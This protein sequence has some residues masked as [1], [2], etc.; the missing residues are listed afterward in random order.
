MAKEKQVKEETKNSFS[1]LE[2]IIL[3]IIAVIVSF[4]L[5]SFITYNINVKDSKK[6]NKY[7]ENI[8]KYYQYIIDNY[9]EDVDKSKLA[10]GAIKGML[11]SLGDEY[12]YVLGEEDA[13]NFDIELEGEY[14]G[15]GIEIVTNNKDEIIIYN[16]LNNSP[17]AKAGLKVGDIIKEVDGIAYKDSKEIA[18]YIRNDASHIIKIKVIRDGKEKE[19]A[20]KKESVTID[21]VMSKTFTKNKKKIGYIYISIFSNSTTKQF[22]DKLK[23][24]EEKDIDALIIDVRDNSGGHLTTATKIISMFLDSSHI[25]YQTDTKG[26][27]EKFYSNG[28]QTKKYPI[29]VLQNSNS[30]SASEMLSAA[31]KEEYKALVVGETSYGKGTVQELTNISKDTELKITTKKWLTPKGNSINKKGVVAD[32]EVKLSDDYKE[33]PSDDN[34][35]QLQKAIEEIAKK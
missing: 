21:S 4:G 33:K 25:I 23:K 35:N 17:A 11:E 27:I 26:K 2:V 9:Y 6:T 5:G 8:N 15:I 34:D 14:Q 16:V 31:L 18:N 22:K 10:S 20:T 29:A 3:I 32:I 13:D 30:A 19:F 12:T 24:L 28:K 7:T 1:S